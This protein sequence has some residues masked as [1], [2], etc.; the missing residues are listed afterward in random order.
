MQVNGHLTF[1]LRLPDLFAE[2]YGKYMEI[3]NVSFSYGQEVILAGLNNPN[4]QALSY[5]FK[6]DKKSWRLFVSTDLKKPE[7]I[8]KEGNGVIGIDL[9][10]DHIA[11]VETDRFGNPVQKQVFLWNSY[12]KRKGQLKA[13]TGDVCKKI[14]EEAK[15]TKK[16]I[17]IEN[18]DFKKKKSALGEKSERK[19]SRLLSSFAYS[20]FFVLLKAR[21]FKN[22]IAVHQVNPAFTSIIGR[23]NY[24]SRYGL[25]SHLAAALCIA[26]RHQKFSE[27]PISPLGKISDGKEGHVTFVLP[28]RNRTKHVWHFWGQVKRKIQTVLAAH[29]RAKYNRSSSPSNDS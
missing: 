10:T 22:G 20:L 24:A 16:P 9:N 11:C 12:G 2:K 5:R 7:L 17:I 28:A 15:K 4:G 21:A 26:R 19:F 3:K 8:S 14:I 25:S 13:I 29:L 27:A 6:K 18:L 23:V 1:R